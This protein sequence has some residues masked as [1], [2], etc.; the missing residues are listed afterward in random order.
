MMTSKTSILASIRRHTIEQ[1]ACPDLKP[2][3]AEALT[4]DDPIA[5]FSEH[6]E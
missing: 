5:A 3:E 6:L 4:Y 2:L 1:F